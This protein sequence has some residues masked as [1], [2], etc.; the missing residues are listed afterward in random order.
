[1]YYSVYQ[2]LG[3]SLSKGSELIK[4]LRNTATGSSSTTTNSLLKSARRLMAVLAALGGFKEYIRTGSHVQVSCKIGIRL[5]R[6]HAS[7]IA[8]HQDSVV[9]TGY[10]E[11]IVLC[12]HE[13]QIVDITIENSK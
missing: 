5:L 3:S 1:M 7:V 2:V 12:V 4:D 13:Y 8:R 11:M 9:S 6:K 10:N